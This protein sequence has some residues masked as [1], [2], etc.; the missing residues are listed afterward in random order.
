MSASTSYV[1]F[2]AGC[3]ARYSTDG[4]T[5]TDLGML[6]GDT[7]AVW[8][9]DINTV[10]GSEGQKLENYKNQTVAAS[11]D[12]ADLN[13][14]ALAALSGGLLT[15]TTTTGSANTSVPD[16]VI[17]ASAW[18]YNTPVAL[19]METS[20][21]DSTKLIASASPTLTSVTGGTDGALTVADD[22]DIIV[23]DSEYGGFSIIVKDSATV[24]T[25]AQ[26]LTIVYASV[27]PTATATMTAGH[28]TYS[29]SSI[30]LQLYSA[31]QG[32]TFT[33]YNVN[34]DSGSYNF[35]FKASDSDGADVMTLSFTG[36]EDVTRTNGDRLFSIAETV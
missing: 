8:N 30:G 9:Y 34:I 32:K 33:M 29:P 7:S 25:V 11:F 3:L 21:T 14:T 24:T 1:N 13:S 28:N 18:A 15:R 17:A 16:Q 6:I 31:A 4:T 26:T 35:G 10:I 2:P 22:Y 27:T 12:L 36:S 19:V 23:D 5:Y 20:S